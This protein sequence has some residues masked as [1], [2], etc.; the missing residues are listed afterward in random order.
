MLWFDP[1]NA[2]EVYFTAQLPHSYKEGSDI[3]AHVHWTPASSTT[4]S[5]NWALNYSWASIG[6]AFTA[7]STISGNTSTPLPTNSTNIGGGHYMTN[8]GT[9]SGTTQ[10]I[11]SMLVCRL[12]RD[13]SGRLDTDDY[14]D[15]AGLLEI[16]FHFERDSIGSREE[17]TK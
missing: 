3:E 13:S 17:Y 4:G 15:D 5:V 16:D 2:E 9:I 6:G 14:S 11:S 12:F 10:G 8:L 1:T 7:E